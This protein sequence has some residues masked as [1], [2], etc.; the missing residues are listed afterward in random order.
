MIKEWFDKRLL[1]ENARIF[2]IF[3]IHQLIV[4]GSGYL[5]KAV[6][7]PQ[8]QHQGFWETV[9]NNLSH[10]DGRWY[11]RIASEGY[12][13]KSTAF[14]PL[15]PM[16]IRLLGCAGIPPEWSG[17]IISNLCFL[18]ACFLFYRLLKDD[19]DEE[20]AARAVWYMAV[21][22]T[23]F[24][25][26]AVYSESLYL[27]LVLGAFY[28]ARRAQWPVCALMGILASS[29]RNTGLLLVIPLSIIYLRAKDYNIR[30]L[31]P[32]ILYLALIP[33]GLA[34]YMVFLW[35]TFHNPLVFVA[36]QQFWNRSF[37]PPWTNIFL[38][39]RNINSNYFMARNLIDLCFTAIALVLTLM[40][41]KRLR[42][43][44]LAYLILGML[45]PLFSKAPQAGLYS[46]P[47]FLLVLFPLYIIMSGLFKREFEHTFIICISS[48][49]LA[50][51]TIM[52]AFGSFVA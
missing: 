50:A 23:A 28:F 20:T 43:E 44:Y 4:L 36:A 41:A 6:S 16:M 48:G 33:I 9:L 12:T 52:F 21:F 47:R 18:I 2:G 7:S 17:I 51:L 40:G 45:V 25:F 10:W 15:Y 42:I 27:A 24:F 35:K 31:R 1:N 29:T 14:F 49:F 8:I 37:S 34:A 5:A 26:S 3:L 30:K 38:T 46:M 19:T 39:W 22:P 32:D 11:L 13:L